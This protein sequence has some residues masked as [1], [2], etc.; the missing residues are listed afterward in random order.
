MEP[1]LPQCKCTYFVVFFPRVGS[2]FFITLGSDLNS[3]DEHIIFGEVTEGHD[4]LLKL[5]D[6]ICDE[7]NRPYQ[8]IRYVDLCFYFRSS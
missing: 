5:N 1:S 2:Q 6:A 4:T 3:L 8:D 7:Q